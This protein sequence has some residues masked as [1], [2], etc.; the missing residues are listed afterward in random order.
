VASTPLGLITFG[1]SVGDTGHR[2]VFFT[3]GRWF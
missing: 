3:V 2:K 1:V